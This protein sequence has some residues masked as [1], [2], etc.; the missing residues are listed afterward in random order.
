MNSDREIFDFCNRAIF[1]DYNSPKCIE[2]F[3]KLRKYLINRFHETI[4]ISRILF[5]LS[6]IDEMILKVFNKEIDNIL[7][8]LHDIRENILYMLSFE[9]TS[10]NELEIIFELE[11]NN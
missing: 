2:E 5:V 10:K 3:N 7:N 6:I 11:E 4:P 8:N 9:V 1:F